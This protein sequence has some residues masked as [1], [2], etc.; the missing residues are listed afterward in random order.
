MESR[1]ISTIVDK[2]HGES[3]QIAT[4]LDQ[5]QIYH[6]AIL[7]LPFLLSRVTRTKMQPMVWILSQVHIFGGNCKTKL[8]Y[9]RGADTCR[10]FI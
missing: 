7:Q 6:R 5:H 10:I 9:A 4:K 1:R 8:R 3:Q 2:E